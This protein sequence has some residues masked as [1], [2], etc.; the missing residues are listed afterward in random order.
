MYA[1]LLTSAAQVEGGIVKGAGDA[2][3]NPSNSQMDKIMVDESL[4]PVRVLRCIVISSMVV[5]SS[6]DNRFLH[7]K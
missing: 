2:L 7:C 6:V 1:K 5:G 3:L 4:C